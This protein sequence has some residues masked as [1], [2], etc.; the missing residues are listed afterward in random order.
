MAN[1]T[2]MKKRVIFM[3]FYKRFYKRFILTLEE[4]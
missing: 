2:K 3:K 1:K 4:I